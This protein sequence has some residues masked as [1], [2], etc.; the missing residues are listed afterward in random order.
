MAHGLQLPEQ[1]FDFRFVLLAKE[2]T[3]ATVTVA[4]RAREEAPHPKTAGE[5]CR[6]SMLRRAY[7]RDVP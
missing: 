2:L 1:A 3:V 5:E 6:R 4:A 7:R